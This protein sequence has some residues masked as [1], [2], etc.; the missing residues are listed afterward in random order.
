MNGDNDLG[1][2]GIEATTRSSAEAVNHKLR[3]EVRSSVAGLRAAAQMLADRQLRMPAGHDARLKKLIVTELE[4][5]DVL[6]TRADS[7]P[8][9][10]VD[11]DGLIAPEVEA[12]RRM[13][14]AVDWEPSGVVVSA[15]PGE[16]ADAIRLLLSHTADLH[17]EARLEVEVSAAGAATAIRFVCAQAGGGT[18]LEPT[19][20]E[21]AK[22]SAA[23]S[24]GDISRYVAHRLIQ[25]AGG[26]LL[27]GRQAAGTAMSHTVLIGQGA[28]R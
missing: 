13:G 22:P 26:T 6:L 25:R 2:P 14:R 21:P 17:P 24:E 1:T 8:R 28:G 27:I 3:H 16:L 4:R 23:S 12:Q 18:W 15:P 11:L 19:P 7:S 9:A 10:D 20:V 5:L